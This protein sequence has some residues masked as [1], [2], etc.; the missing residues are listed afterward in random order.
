LRAGTLYFPD[1]AR[2][3]PVGAR[4]PQ[5]AAL[6]AAAAVRWAVERA[7]VIRVDVPGPHPALA[8]LLEAGFRITYVETFVASSAEPLFDPARYLGSGGSLF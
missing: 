7:P 2:V 6:C 4:T 5:H 1:A 3:G 8:P